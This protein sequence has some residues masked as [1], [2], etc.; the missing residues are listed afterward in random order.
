[1]IE[2]DTPLQEGKVVAPDG[3]CQ[4]NDGKCDA[5]VRSQAKNF[6]GSKYDCV[7]SKADNKCIRGTRTKEG[8][9]Y[10]ED[11]TGCNPTPCETGI[12]SK[13][14]ASLLGCALP[15]LTRTKSFKQRFK[16]LPRHKTK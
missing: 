15:T 2:A 14:A 12:T 13:K 6:W 7:F 8:H 11:P 9:L 16:S 1:M 4:S 3:K 5:C 10:A